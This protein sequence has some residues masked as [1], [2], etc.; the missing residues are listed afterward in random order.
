MMS[1]MI[2]TWLLEGS[3][4]NKLFQ[5]DC[6]V[7]NMLSGMNRT[8]LKG[9]MVGSVMLAIKVN[10]SGYFCSNCTSMSNKKP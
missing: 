10:R 3:K 2:L 9:R 7:A 5:K 6:D 8:S 4:V 1:E